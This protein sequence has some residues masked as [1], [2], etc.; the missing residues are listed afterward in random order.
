M[1]FMT[2]L[3]GQIKQRF[4]TVSIL[5]NNAGISPKRADGLSNGILDVTIQ[6]WSKVLLVSVS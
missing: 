1:A 5:V 2:R 6:E 3:Q 4:G